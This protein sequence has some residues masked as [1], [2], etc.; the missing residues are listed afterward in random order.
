MLVRYKLFSALPMDFPFVTGTI[1]ILIPNKFT[2]YFFQLSKGTDL[3]FKINWLSLCV[4]HHICVLVH[5]HLYMG[6]PTL[7]RH[8]TKK[9]YSVM[10]KTDSTTKYHQ[11][12]QTEFWNH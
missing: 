7:G 3:L 11:L 9:C 8:K 10:K 5:I 12:G 2:V 4:C 1:L 6:F